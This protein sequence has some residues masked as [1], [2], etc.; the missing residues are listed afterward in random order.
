MGVNLPSHLELYIEELRLTGFS[1]SQGRKIGDAIEVELARLLG[2]AGPSALAGGALALDRLDAG[3][4]RVAPGASARH[5]GSQIAQAL[6]HGLTH[7]ASKG[8]RR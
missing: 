2:E 1:A 4:I 5:T 6:M 8:R 3:K 7:P